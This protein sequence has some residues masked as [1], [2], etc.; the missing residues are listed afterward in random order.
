[1]KTSGTNHGQYQVTRMES[2]HTHEL[3]EEDYICYAK[4]RKLSSDEEED[5][6]NQLKNKA[7]PAL[8]VLYCQRKFK[9]MV[10]NRDLQNIRATAT[11]KAHQKNDTNHLLIELKKVVDNQIKTDGGDYFS[12]VHSKDDKKELYGIL[13]Q[14]PYMKKLYKAY[15]DSL[16]F[17]FTYDTNTSE[18]PS[19]VMTVLDNN[20][21]S[22]I[23]GIAL[24]A[25][26]REILTGALMDFFLANNDHRITEIITI[27]KDL[28]EARV[29]SEKFPNARILYC[30]WHVGKIFERRIKSEDLYKILIEMRDSTQ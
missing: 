25:Y 9:K 20:L 2:S 24:S 8:V 14:D 17:D 6:L 7:K 5:V 30:T 4:K 22:R 27:D 3:N 12:Y 1:L 13:Y 26:E 21:T 10:T 11:K 16:H 29:L 18:Y 19:M 23:V 15:G 28:K